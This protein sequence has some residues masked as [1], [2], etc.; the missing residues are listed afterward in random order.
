MQ[1]VVAKEFKTVNR[2]FKPG[3]VVSV[4]DIEGDVPFNQ[5]IARGFIASKSPA[6]AS[7]PRMK[8]SEEASV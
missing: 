1:Y 6:P 2:K 5:W 3:D 7:F 8:K 4:A